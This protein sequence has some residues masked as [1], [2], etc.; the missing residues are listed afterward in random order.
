[1]EVYSLNRLCQVFSQ[2][3]FTYYLYPFII[4]DGNILMQLSVKY[5]EVIEAVR[6]LEV[7]RPVGEGGGRF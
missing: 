5:I 6:V 2:C 1:M 7:A 4:R 3:L